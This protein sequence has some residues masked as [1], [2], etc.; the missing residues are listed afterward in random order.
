MN[1]LSHDDAYRSAMNAA[2]DQLGLI[3]EEAIWVS[4]R[5]YQLD[6]LLEA[7]KPFMSSG[8]GTTAADL[9]ISASVDLA[10]EAVHADGLT[11]Q[12]VGRAIP[13]VVTREVIESADPIQRRINSV[14]GL[15]VAS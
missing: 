5:M 2:L 13:E 11:P 4:N 12:L 1:Q 7:L 9:P 10:A 8:D 14:L 3:D 6:S 15:A